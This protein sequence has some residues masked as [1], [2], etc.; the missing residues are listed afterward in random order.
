MNNWLI[1]GTALESFYHVSCGSDQILNQKC[2][3]V[4]I[5]NAYTVACKFKFDH[6]CHYHIH[7]K[8]QTFFS[9]LR[10]NFYKVPHCV[11]WKA[12]SDI[13]AVMVH[14]WAS[15]FCFWHPSEYFLLCVCAKNG[16][17][18]VS[19]LLCHASVTMGCFYSIHRL[20]HK[21]DLTLI[22]RSWGRTGVKIACEAAV[23]DLS[24]MSLI[25]ERNQL[26]LPE[27]SQQITR[28]FLKI[29][30]S[31]RL[32]MTINAFIYLF[33]ISIFYIKL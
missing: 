17:E 7:N 24:M 12:S 26:G 14:G 21:T 30:P 16:P 20:K 31:R 2:W 22:Y 15:C 1:L 27:S 8:R 6:A 23:F 9:Q 19:A 10:F 5:L 4:W 11:P 33:P 25:Q 18:S 13:A 29:F 32:C 28:T 3:S